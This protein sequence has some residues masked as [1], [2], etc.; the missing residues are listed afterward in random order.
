MPSFGLELLWAQK[1]YSGKTKC[2]MIPSYSESRK[3]LPCLIDISDVQIEEVLD[4]DCKKMN[5]SSS[6]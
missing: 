1:S 3:L 6:Q 5:Y 4:V 2:T